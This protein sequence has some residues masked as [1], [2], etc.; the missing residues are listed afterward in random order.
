MMKSI[1]QKKR[2]KRILTKKKNRVKINKSRKNKQFGSSRQKKLQHVNCSPKE[3][4]EM[5]N[6]TCY[7]DKSLYKLLLKLEDQILCIL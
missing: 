6:F 1:T 5:N 2:T 3:K 4:R 7:T